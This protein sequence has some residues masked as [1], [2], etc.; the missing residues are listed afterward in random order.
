MHKSKTEIQTGCCYV[1]TNCIWLLKYWCWN[2]TP[3][4]GQKNQYFINNVLVHIIFV[5]IFI[6]IYQ[7]TT[8]APR[9]ISFFLKQC[10]KHPSSI[11]G[12]APL[13][14]ALSLRSP[15][16]CFGVCTAKRATEPHRIRLLAN[17]ERPFC[18]IVRRR[19]CKTY[20]HSRRFLFL[21]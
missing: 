12:W 11:F 20:P 13:F 19:L 21:Q 15:L 5:Y 16:Y 9:R 1:A 18:G 3:A 8:C 17:S 4:I 6:L 7:L 14:A 2:S 10:W